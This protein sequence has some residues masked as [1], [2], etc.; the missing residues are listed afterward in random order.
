MSL[1]VP[2]AG[3]FLVVSAC[4]TAGGEEEARR[5]E[6]ARRRYLESVAMRAEAFAARVAPRILEA[7]PGGAEIAV[8][9]EPESSALFR[10]ICEQGEALA[11]VARDGPKDFRF[12]R[13]ESALIRADEIAHDTVAIALLKG[14]L[15]AP[16]ERRDELLAHLGVKAE[17]PDGTRLAGMDALEDAGLLDAD[18]QVVL[19]PRDTAEYARYEQWESIEAPAFF[20]RILLIQD[21][22]RDRSDDI[23]FECG[24]EP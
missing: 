8:E 19:P 22:E 14:A 13:V 17:G 2:L 15:S 18:G 9:F 20:G 24:V 11:E 7:L 12:S 4:F 23:L 10:F 1:G 5:F 16:T 6:E 3:A 21:P